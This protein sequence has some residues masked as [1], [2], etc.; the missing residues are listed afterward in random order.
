MQF[1]YNCRIH[2]NLVLERIIKMSKM[3]SL[4]NVCSMITAAM[5]LWIGSG[6]WT[7][8]T[9]AEVTGELKQWHSVTISF[10]GPEASEND[11]ATFRDY[12]LTVTFT[13]GEETCVVPGYFAADGDAANSGAYSGNIWRVHFIPDKTG[14]WHY[15]ASFRAGEDIAIS[16]DSEAG[17]PASFDGEAGAFTITESDK[18]GRDHR[19]KGMLRYVNKHHYR[20][21][22]SGEYFL[23]GGADSPENFLAFNDFD[24]TSRHAYTDHV[25]DWN[26]GDTTWGDGKG[27]GII[28]AL[29]Y[30]S[31][32]G[33][34]SVY[35]LTDNWR[36]DGNDVFPWLSKSDNVDEISKYDCSKLD[37]W[38][39]VFSH[40]DKVGIQFYAILSETEN[41][42]FFEI[43]ELGGAGGTR[44]ADTRKLYYREIIARF[45]HHP[46]VHWNIGEENGWSLGG[47]YSGSGT[48]TDQRKMYAEYIRDVDPYDHPVGVHSIQNEF[49]NYPPLY[50]DPNF[51]SA[52]FQVFPQYAHQWTIDARNG[53]AQAGRPW[54]VYY[55][56]IHGP[57]LEE[58]LSNLDELRKDAM[59]IGNFIAGGA[60]IEWYFQFGDLTTESWK[61]LGRL[62]DETRYALEFFQ[63]NVNF[64]DM[65]PSDNLVSGGNSYC[66]A[67]EGSAYVVYLRNGGT[68]TLD[69]SGTTG[70]FDVQWYDPRNGGGLQ[71]GSVTTVSGGGAVAIGNPPEN[72]DDD[73]AVLISSTAASHTAPHITTETADG[74]LSY[75]NGVVDF[76]LRQSGIVTVELVQ[77]N[78]RTARTIRSGMMSAGS[79][80]VTLGMS[81][82]SKGVY[83]MRVR[84][85][86]RTVGGR[87]IHIQ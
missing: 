10:N 54:A 19:G 34:N 72:P 66:M 87:L 38:D 11:P 36:G 20:F 21:A 71:N 78:G 26:S 43:V 45:S 46:A 35:A 81:S 77:V 51:E 37:Q 85:D 8:L 60:G 31:G 18:T 52:T 5:S 50:G 68:A 29:N 56:E 6:L 25:S 12:R 53:S 14:E 76:T 64:Q 58:N 3:L 59:W 7:P 27:K 70:D 2:L 82:L 62:W 13:N 42:Q 86:G 61:P 65:V 41:E 22:G 69:L 44:F 16:L 15:S 40:M 23:R 55:D 47:T 9:A 30:L 75:R 48:T 63:D 80:A 83:C 57:T 67:E 49:D 84:S 79:H 28:G 73:W 32:K 24:N 39:I 4:K 74:D 33:M 1:S 17:S